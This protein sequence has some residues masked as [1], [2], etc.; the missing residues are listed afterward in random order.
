M[1]E[2]IRYP[3]PLLR[4]VAKPVEVIDETIRLL[5]EEM[6]EAMYDEKGVGLAAPQVG[7]S[8]RVVVVDLDYK[9]RDPRVLINPAL[10]GR[11]KEKETDTEGCLS[12]PGVNASVTRAAECDIEALDLNGATVR[13]H[14]SGIVSRAFQHETDHLDGILFIDKVTPASRLAIREELRRLEEAYARGR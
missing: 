2:I 12:V 1:L 14:G 8:L 4:Q 5:A 6:I 11:S 10:V 7:V 13:Y 9:R 3:D